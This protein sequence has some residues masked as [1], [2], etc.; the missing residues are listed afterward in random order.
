MLEAIRKHTGGIVVKALMGLLI[1][2][3]AIWGIG[4]I[5]MGGGSSSVAATV[6]DE[7]ISRNRLR[8]EVQRRLTE[9]RKLTGQTLTEEQTRSMGINRA[10]LNQLIDTTLISQGAGKLGITISNDQVAVAI[11]E[12]KQFRSEL[13][14]FDRTRFTQAMNNLGLS[15]TGYVQLLRGDMERNQFV[16]SLSLGVVTPKK[17]TDDLYR[18]RMEQRTAET[19]RIPDSAAKDLP[20]P[21]EATLA[22]FH[23][24]KASRFT[25]PEH[26]SLTVISMTADDL[27]KE[28]AVSEDET[29]AS[30]DQRVHEFSV[31]EQRDIM[32]M[33]FTEEKTA[34]KAHKMLAEGR[35]F[36][37]VGKEVAGQEKDLLSFGFMTKEQ[38]MP[39]LAAS[40]FSVDKGKFSEPVKSPLGWHL[41]RVKD[42]KE[43]RSK[44]YAE[45][46]DRLKSDIARE[47]A[48]DGLFG[49]SNKVEDE[50]GGGATLREAADRLGLKV[51]KISSV[52]RAGS[53]AK[54]NPV[55]N[56]PKGEFLT[57]AFETL[58]GEDSQMTEAGSDG[59]FALKVDGVTP[60]VLRPLDTVRK[61]VTEAWKQT[62]RAEGARKLAEKL[63]AE[64]KG[65]GTDMAAIAKT[66]GFDYKETKD[67]LRQPNRSQASLPPVL[68]G[69]L[70]EMV[71]GEAAFGRDGNSYIVARLKKVKPAALGADKKTHTALSNKIADGIRQ[72][73]V[74]QLADGLRKYYG[75]TINMQALNAPL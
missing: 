32:Q 46:K 6:G 38:M 47:K 25:A 23:K 42:V 34:Q 5:G 28:I 9:F 18:H 27:A 70:F 37:D 74:R 2:S 40:A 72:D 51:V 57:V 8:N 19:I 1:L 21:D 48:L 30:Y 49:L 61:E 4:D 33:V 20:K 17:L 67:L 75:V 39:E 14:S 36:E 66:K 59:Y 53:D 56:L 68:T 73:L 43:G 29:K 65:S 63:T 24:D 26:R 35:A 3:F 10:T 71:P 7:E 64:I 55:P 58:L 52:D 11:R 44:T 54:G 41:I 12:N 62:Q 13:G 69:K 60:S 22:K 31:A 45:L 15:E 50:L 16:S